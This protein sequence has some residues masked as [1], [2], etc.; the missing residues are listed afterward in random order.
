MNVQAANKVGCP[1]MR[2]KASRTKGLLLKCPG[3]HAT[4]TLYQNPTKQS[5]V[6]HKASMQD[7]GTCP[8]GGVCHTS[9]S[10]AYGTRRCESAVFQKLSCSRALPAICRPEWAL[11]L[12]DD[13]YDDI[14]Q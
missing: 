13:C 11:C 9:P 3:L 1:R 5:V 6:Q 8:I 4:H 14:S 2:L 7:T 12:P 10:D